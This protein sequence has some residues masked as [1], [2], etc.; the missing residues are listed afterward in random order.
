MRRRGR[1]GDVVVDMRHETIN[2]LVATHC[3]ANV[4]PEQWDVEGL[5]AAAADTL[6]LDVPEGVLFR[7]DKGKWQTA[8]GKGI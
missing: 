6:A 1:V 3:P 7:I 8:T 4:Y 5:T 2:T